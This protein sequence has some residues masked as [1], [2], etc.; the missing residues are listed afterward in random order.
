MVTRMRAAA[1]TNKNVAENNLINKNK[2]KA[3]TTLASEKQKRSAFGDLTNAISKN[4]DAKKA[5]KGKVVAATRTVQ[6]TRPSIK[7][8]P[9]IKEEVKITEPV[10]SEATIYFSPENIKPKRMLPPNVEDFDSE[11]G[12]DPFQTPQYA[13]DIFLYFK[14]RESKFIPRRYMEQQTELTCDMR[15]VLVDWLVEVQESFELNHETLYSAVRLVDLYLS[16]KTVNKENLQLVGTTAMLISSKF[17]ERCPPCVDD[18]LYICDDAY[19]RCDLIRMEMS[20]LKAVDFDIGLPL[21]YS[22]LRRYARV[23]YNPFAIRFPCS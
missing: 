6:L 18:F 12:N 19:T 9:A 1:T 21:S 22:F 13:H 10:E 20:I 7:I 5:A 23:R 16:H 14:Q 15:S 2:R 3:E 17:E 8:V 11:C 4:Q